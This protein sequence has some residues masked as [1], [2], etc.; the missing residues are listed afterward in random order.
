MKKIYILLFS[1]FLLSSCQENT[2]TKEESNKKT[3]HSEAPKNENS[4][5]TDNKEEPVTEVIEN[6]SSKYATIE[7]YAVYDTKEKLTAEFGVENL[8]HGSSWYAEGTV[9]INHTI[10]TNPSNGNIVKY[11][12]SKSAPE[13]LSSLEVHYTIFNEDF[14]P[15]GTQNIA[16][17][18][19][20]HTGMSLKEL[21]SWNEGHITFSGFGWDY[22]GGILS[23]E[24]NKLSDCKTQVTLSID[25]N[26]WANDAPDVIGDSEFSTANSDILNSPIFVEQLT[27]YVSDLSDKI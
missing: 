2:T 25:Y 7:S 21:H 12:W 15:L 20:T 8:S 3:T 4:E 6:T 23:S 11:L 17:S 19:G 10:L 14:E 24:G 16:S 13:N 1:S 5:Q 27:Y 9:E 22:S 26:N 18:C